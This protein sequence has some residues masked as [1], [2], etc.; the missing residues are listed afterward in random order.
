MTWMAYQQNIT[1]IF[2]LYTKI[3]NLIITLISL[4]MP[5]LNHTWGVQSLCSPTVHPS[6]DL[7]AGNECTVNFTDSKDRLH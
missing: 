7:L 5:K 4:F 6:F 2:V 1:N 3:S